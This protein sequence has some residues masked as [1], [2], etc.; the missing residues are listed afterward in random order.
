MKPS[1]IFHPILTVDNCDHFLFIFWLYI[2]NKFK[3]FLGRISRREDIF[4]IIDQICTL[5]NNPIEISKTYLP[6]S[7]KRL[8]VHVEMIL[9]FWRLLETNE[10]FV[11]CLLETNRVL[12]I[13]SSLIH[14][15]FESKD[16]LGEYITRVF[17]GVLI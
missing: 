8:N 1:V 4:L 14:Y 16:D 5:L 17:F 15:L 7:T 3:Y 6:G 9:L 11:Q 10:K 2:A 13:L 12:D